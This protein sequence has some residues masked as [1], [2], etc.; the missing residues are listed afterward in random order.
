MLIVQ[1]ILIQLDPRLSAIKI[2]GHSARMT[3][4]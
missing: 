1:A 4:K 3:E 2:G